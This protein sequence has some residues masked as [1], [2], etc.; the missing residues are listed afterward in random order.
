MPQWFEKRLRKKE[1]EE[2]S[3]YISD[4]HNTAGHPRFLIC[5]MRGILVFL[6]SYATIIG[7]MDAFSLPFNRPAVIA[8]L[9]F[10]SMTVALL[11]FRKILF[12]SGYILILIIFVRQLIYYYLYANSGYQA[13]V[14]VIYEQYS[15]YF[16]LSTLRQAQEFYTSRYE[17]VTIALFFIGTFLALL[18]NVTISG[19]MN[20]P[21][22]VLI[23]FPFLEIA[24]YIDKK[25]P[26]H[27]MLLLFSVYLCVAIQQA[28][29]NFR[30]QVKGKHTKEYLKLKRPKQTTYLY[31]GNA[32]GILYSLILSLV[33]I[34]GI[35]LCASPI[36]YAEK[37]PSK[38]NAL[39]TEADNLIKIYLQNGVGGLFDRYEA[40]GGL[41][42][43]R[44][45]G[46]SSV[47]PDFQT[48]VV[49]TFAPYT[50][51]TIYLKGFTGSY[52]HQNQWLG[53]TYNFSADGSM[54][55]S[56]ASED[57]FKYDQTYSPDTGA[58][59][60]M[61]IENVD[62]FDNE[63]LAPYYS[64]PGQTSFPLM[65]TMEIMYDPYQP[66][67]FPS[68]QVDLPE[69]YRDYIYNEC[70]E[71]PEHLQS[72]LLS[73]CHEAGFNAPFADSSFREAP[74]YVGSEEEMDLINEQRRILAF[75][76]Y[77]HFIKNYDYTMSPGA[78]PVNDDFVQY[79]LSTQKRGYCVHFASSAV[80]LLRTMGVPCRYAEGYCLPPTLVAEGQPV[81]G[82][83]V[84]D[85]YT[86]PTTLQ[87]QGI[88]EVDVNDSYAHAWIEIYME[89]YGFIPFEVTPADMDDDMGIP[90]IAGLFSGLFDIDFNMAELPDANPDDNITQPQEA[91]SGL[92]PSISSK[93]VLIPFA[94]FAGAFLLIYF[95]VRITILI[96]RQKR[97][98]KWL[99]QGNYKE[100]IYQDYTLLTETLFHRMLRSKHYRKHS[101]LSKKNIL[102][103]DLCKLML[104][105]YEEIQPEEAARDSYRK[106]LENFR[107]YS[108][109]GMYSA[110][111]LTAEEYASY[112]E[113][114]LEVKKLCKL[115]K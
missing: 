24:F 112:T 77:S 18:L 20:T 86:G 37:A 29:R 49:V 1:L 19:Y 108:L 109:K 85:W 12:Y 15:D 67:S 66:M 13:I 103:D 11:Y 74:D 61:L 58:Q 65:S 100:L 16:K 80:M 33:L 79:F 14:N 78:S 82:E 94:I 52:Y 36:Y 110:T 45:G 102:P 73:Y 28:S 50:Y 62:L 81:A 76:V 57:I 5:L 43:G 114:Y 60:K 63:V 8:F 93:A 10:I 7:V 26:L 91:L 44:L 30:M 87:E 105:L 34:F 70:L 90:D 42:S 17:T 47:R 31:Q 56:L 96:L 69:E 115:I 83:S 46:V 48:D 104:Q 98:Q 55:L 41:S 32:T 111:G 6:A 84:S 25:P 107:I 2:N 51:E 27:C 59:G 101:A 54:E 40:K 106:S 99:A 64:Y 22:T 89:G 75:E 53:N 68:S 113:S 21:E 9:F 97:R 95:S 92:F 35:G 88:I 4:I 23:T 38:P 72:Y 71:V 3:F 39:R